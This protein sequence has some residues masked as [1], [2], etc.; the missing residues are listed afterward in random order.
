MFFKKEI[1]RDII[2]LATPVVIASLSQT[3]I[4]LLDTAFLGRLPDEEA[5]HSLAAVGLGIIFLWVIGGFF[6]AIGV[7]TQ[8][9]V[10]RREGEGKSEEA[11]RAV[12]NSLIYSFLSGGLIGLL[13][14]FLTPLIFPR[15]SSDHNVIDA[16]IPFVK[17]RFLGLLPMLTMMSLKG[18]FDGI[19]ITKIYMNTTII[20]N[21]YNA[22]VGYL[23]ILGKAG[24]PKMGTKGAGIAATSA[25]YIGAVYMISVS[26]R[27]AYKKYKIWSR[28]NLSL[29]VLKNI[30]MVSI[31]A[32]ISASVTTLGFLVFIWIVGRIGTMEQAISNI[33]IQF[34]SFIFMPCIGI[35]IASATYMG[36]KLGKK[37]PYLAKTYVLEAIKIGVMVVGGLGLLEFFLSKEILSL[38]T[39]NEDIWFY[40][41]SAFKI[42]ALSQFLIAID[43]I[44]SYSLLGAGDSRFVMT[45]EITSH[46]LFFLPLVYLLG[47]KAHMGLNG[48]WLS[49]SIYLL[50]ISAILSFRFLSMKWAKI[51]L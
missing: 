37:E 16:G 47:I 30:L 44:L 14:W 17:I 18:F 40:G 9:V 22:I 11:G 45:A 19:G 13:G 7:G 33:L 15:L 31:P 27:S 43:L 29:S 51:K 41:E 32:G 10:S 6:N 1:S 8:A 26:L 12:F 23:L 28:K 25:S 36:Q 39:S 4:N 2:Y 35:G 3:L 42:L 5:V 50:L 38:F 21:I 20:M 24:F 34:S 49:A 46:W 48:A